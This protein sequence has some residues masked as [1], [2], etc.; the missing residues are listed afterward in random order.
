MKLTIERLFYK[1]GYTIGNMYL[2]GQWLCNT[3]EPPRGTALEAVTAGSGKAIQ[4]GTY[5]VKLVLSPRFK[6]RLP[7]LEDISAPF[8]TR[9]ETKGGGLGARSGILI[10]AGNTAK[11]TQGC[12][13]VGMNTKV[14]SVMNSKKCLKKITSAISKAEAAKEPVVITIR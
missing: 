7:R 6:Q 5:R 4:A 12:I 14:G 13:L 1:N 3:L 8:P 2:N 9:G 10:H 11:D